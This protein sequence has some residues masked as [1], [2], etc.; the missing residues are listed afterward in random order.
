V[1]VDNANPA[2]LILFTHAKG[3]AVK[4]TI[5]PSATQHMR[6]ASVTL[7]FMQGGRP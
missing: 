6:A 2:E 5:K 3:G 4:L 7:A 1:G